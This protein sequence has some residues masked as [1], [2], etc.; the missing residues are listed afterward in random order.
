MPLYNLTDLCA[1]GIE[2]GDDFTTFA[3]SERRKIDLL[4]ALST[5]AP[6]I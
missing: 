5:L 2:P 4:K 6:K 3:A 1:S